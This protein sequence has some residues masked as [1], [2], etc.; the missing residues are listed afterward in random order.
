MRP[1]C[2]TGGIGH[3]FAVFLAFLGAGP[4]L[5]I[6]GDVPLTVLNGVHPIVRVSINGAAPIAML[7]DTGAARTMVAPDYFRPGKV[8]LCFEDGTCV[9]DSLKA[10][11]SPYS[12]ARPGYINGLIGYS[13]LAKLQFTLDYRA[14]RMIIGTLPAG[15]D[16]A[17]LPF[18]I[19]H[20]S[21]PHMAV[22]VGRRTFEKVLLDTGSSYTR[23]KSTT[24]MAYRSD[25]IEYSIQMKR[26]EKT[27]LSAPMPVCVQT[28]CAS[29]V[30]V[31]KASWAAIGGSF[32]NRFRVGIDGPGNRLLLARQPDTPL[33][34]AAPLR[35]YGLQ[36]STADASDIVYI[37]RGS[38]AARAKLA[39]TDRIA[40][41][42]GKPIETLGYIGAI[43]TMEQAAHV[44][45]TLQDGRRVSL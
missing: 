34:A 32:L 7:V 16:T 25:S 12:L 4:V 20:T 3:L 8:S 43:V 42:N 19:D 39:T 28:V 2:L 15:K 30:I 36:I 26:R 40:A 41:I 27:T 23:V 35:R 11:D 13:A 22:S 1:D 44:E 31:Q 14:G 29:N 33:E 24:G 21:R 38:A 17:S 37:R 45:L 18:A 10:A 9:S 5:A 6:A